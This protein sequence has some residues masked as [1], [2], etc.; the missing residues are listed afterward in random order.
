MRWIRRKAG[1]ELIVGRKLADG[2]LGCSVPC[3]IC[4]AVLDVFELRVTCV[5][6]PGAWF[7]GKLTD[8]GAPTAKLTAAQKQLVQGKRSR[9]DSTTA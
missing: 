6:E 8:E 5:V 3:L 2:S 7:R 1:S 9:K 4:K